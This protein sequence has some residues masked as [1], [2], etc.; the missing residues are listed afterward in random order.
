MR[1]TATILTVTH[2]EVSKKYGHTQCVAAVDNNTK[3][4]IRIY[5]ITP[6]MVQKHNIHRGAVIA[7]DESKRP[8]TDKR[9]ESIK[10]DMDSVK[11]VTE[12]HN[13]FISRYAEEHLVGCSTIKTFRP[14]KRPDPSFYLQQVR[15]VRPRTKKGVPY[16]FY[17]CQEPGCKGHMRKCLD[18]E[19]QDLKD[20]DYIILGRHSQEFLSGA[21]LVGVLGG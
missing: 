9:M 18:S 17:K 3:E 15:D 11:Y 13:G 1:R 7:F 5:P 19:R 6:E 21:M 8:N 2:E 4:L 10:I 16:W 20:G 14:F 12:I